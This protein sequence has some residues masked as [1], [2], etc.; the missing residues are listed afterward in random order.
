MSKLLNE[1][2]VL[3]T[4]VRLSYPALFEPRGFE[5]QEPKYSA[6]IIIPKDDK[7]NLKVIKQAIENAKK[8]GLERGTWK[9][10]K[11]PTN[12]KSP[13]RDG[14][15]DRPDDDVYEGAYFIN[16]NSK[17][18]PAVVGKEKDRA[19]GKAITLGEEDVYAGCYVNVTINFYGYSAAGNNGIAAG[20]GNVQ[21]EAD[22]ENL[23][24]RSSAESDFDFVEVDSDDDFLF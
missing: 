8:V 10:N 17:F 22:G 19:T 7:E 20:L 6:S 23:G 4:N 1:T 21:K 18:A 11:L 5:G 12:L 9:G 15:T 13:V 3:L 24:G 16:A 2:K 14:D